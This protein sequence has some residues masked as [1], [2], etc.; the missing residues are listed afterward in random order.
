MPQWIFD[1]QHKEELIESIR[2]LYEFKGTAKRPK[3]KIFGEIIDFITG[4]K[5][6]AEN[7]RF[8]YEQD[9]GY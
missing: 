9:Y 1:K 2:D 3:E 8:Y 5:C 6:Q 7:I 4:Q